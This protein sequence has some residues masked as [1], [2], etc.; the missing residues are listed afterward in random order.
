MAVFSYYDRCRIEFS[1][2]LNGPRKYRVSTNRP[3]VLESHSKMACD[4]LHLQWMHVYIENVQKFQERRW[5]LQSRR[6]WT[7]TRGATVR[8]SLLAA[9]M[10]NEQLRTHGALNYSRSYAY[11]EYCN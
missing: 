7:A 5:L 10:R 1:D 11:A 9:D 8:N 4:E 2:C 6:L 3:F